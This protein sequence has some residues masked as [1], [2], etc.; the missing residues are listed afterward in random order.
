MTVVPPAANTASKDAV[1]VVSRS[2]MR[3]LTGLTCSASSRETLR[4]CWVAQSAT[5]LAVT[6]AI[7]SRRV[8]W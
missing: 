3:T 5:G 8:S 7:R 6:P 4:A 2:R 1:N